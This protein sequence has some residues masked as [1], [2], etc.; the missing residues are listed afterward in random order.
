MKAL[1]QAAALSLSLLLGACASAM[2]TMPAPPPARVNVASLPAGASAAAQGENEL[3]RAVLD[4]INAYRAQH[5]V[6]ALADDA[7]LQRAA[8]V[9]SADMS[10]RNFIG[11]YNPDGQG[12]KERVL[13]VSPDFK[14]DLAE[15]I[16]VMDGMGGKSAN[17]IAAEF[18]K[19]WVASPGHRKNL[20]SA[21]Y[22][23]SGV[24]IARKG[25]TVFATELFAG[26]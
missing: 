11:H 14:S 18:V 25:D 15:N 12:P 10:L 7:S 24:G 26:P 1:K 22:T 4:A 13:A 5:D 21:D 20:K 3:S 19:Q 23:R 6:P 17:A 2:S 16:A 8:A 9:H